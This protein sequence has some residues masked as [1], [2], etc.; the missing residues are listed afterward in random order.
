MKRTVKV[1]EQEPTL[2]E[3]ILGYGC[4]VAFWWL[5][6]ESIYLWIFG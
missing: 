3:Y 2:L 5:F 6:F 1:K 4:I